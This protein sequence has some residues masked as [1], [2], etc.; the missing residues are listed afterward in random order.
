MVKGRGKLHMKQRILVPV[1]VASL[2]VV[3]MV[4]IYFLHSPIMSLIL[5]MCMFAVLWGYSVYVKA[6]AANERR[7]LLESVQK[8][9]A[10]T[11]SHHRH[12]WMNDLQILYGYIQLRK[13][14][15]L[16]A[17]VE[18]IKERM[19][20]ESKISRLGIP[21]LIFY[22]QSFREINKQ[23]QLTV[24]IED[25]LQL[26]ELCSEKEAQQ[27]TSAIVETITAYQFKDRVSWGELVQLTVSF[28]QDQGHIYVSFEQESRAN[29]IDTI[30]LHI[31][32]LLAGTQMATSWEDEEN[33]I[34]L[35]S[36]PCS[37]LNEVS[38]CS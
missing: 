19:L 27:L 16:T 32:D 15:K 4:L 26:D 11:L 38:A 30:K 18:R 23:V 17:C 35:L 6:Q 25:D 24:L 7:S 31:E 12:D 34:L 33:S 2:S 29:N 3:C 9:A 10:A 22:L 8:T 13:Y 14:D 37:K 20:I 1:I 21:S 36:M 28:Y 5:S